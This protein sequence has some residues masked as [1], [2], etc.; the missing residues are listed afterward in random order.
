[1]MPITI[2]SIIRWIHIL[3]AILWIGGMFFILLV[4]LPILRRALPKVE[5]TLVLAK[6]G[7][8]FGVLSIV[9]LTMLI[10][11]GYFNAVHRHVVWT[12]LDDSQYGRTLGLKL[13]LVAVVI[14]VT[15]VHALYFGRKMTR[16]AERA[17]EMSDQD[18]PGLAAARRRAAVGS[19]IL[20]ALNLLLNLAIVLLAA[21]LVP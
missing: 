10:V 21:S 18:D 9:A 7:E 17:K 2:W 20:S 3:A 1:M 5:R 15:F 6:A 13:I 14:V 12:R 8:R 16:L 19:G 4:L 11:T